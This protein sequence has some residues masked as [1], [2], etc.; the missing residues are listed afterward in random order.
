MKFIH[1]RLKNSET[2][3]VWLLG[4]LLEDEGAGKCEE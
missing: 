1:Y 3:D 4:K 2:I